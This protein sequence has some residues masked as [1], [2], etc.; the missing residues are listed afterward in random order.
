[1]KIY[2]NLELQDMV[3]EVEMIPMMSIDDEEDL[4]KEDIPTAVPLLPLRNN[5]LLS[6]VIIPISVG[7]ERSTKAI[8][9]AHKDDKI[10]GVIAQK[11]V[12]IDE[13]E[14]DDLYKIGTLARI[15]KIIK[16]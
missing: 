9:Q 7:R 11:D 5:V 2:K 1:M 6:G 12:N 4:K 14:I 10:I 3:N 13:P 15:L 16:M 8:K